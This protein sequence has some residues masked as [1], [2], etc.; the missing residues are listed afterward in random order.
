MSDYK[1]QAE[2]AARAVLSEIGAEISDSD[3]DAIVGLMAT[4]WLRGHLAGSS[5]TINAVR[6]QYERD[7]DAALAGIRRAV[8]SI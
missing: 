3:H 5:E 4:A 7:A 1:Q 6:E 2:D 8:E